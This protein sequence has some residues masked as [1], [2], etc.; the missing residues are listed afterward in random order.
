M[1]SMLLSGL[2][3][4]AALAAA[5]IT[6]A[7]AQMSGGVS[8]TRGIP[9]GGNNGAGGNGGVSITRGI[10]N[11]GGVHGNLT[12]IGQFG[13]KPLGGHICPLK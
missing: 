10:P 4:I 7:S 12:C 9:N 1:R 13:G 5:S 3:V 11:G 6:P 2:A 8:I